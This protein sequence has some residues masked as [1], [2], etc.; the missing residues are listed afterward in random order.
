MHSRKS[1]RGGGRALTGVFLFLAFCMAGCGDDGEPPGEGL[2]ASGGG[3]HEHIYIGSTEASGGTLFGDFD[4]DG[5]RATAYFTECLGGNDDQCTGGVAIYTATSP[6]FASVEPDE[7][8]PGYHAV[9]DDTPIRLE[10][11]AIDAAVSVRVGT[12]FMRQVGDSDL[13]GTTPFHGHGEFLVAVPGP[14]T[15]PASRDHGAE[16]V[17]YP[18]SFRFT[19]SAAQF[20]PSPSYTLRIVTSTDE[21]AHGHD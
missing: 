1:V 5:K 19:S 15:A 8:T 13:V 12:R 7:E 20:A 17:E 11:T 16:E 3:G 9:P 21:D 2:P 4:F 14:S 10:I 18:V 6:A